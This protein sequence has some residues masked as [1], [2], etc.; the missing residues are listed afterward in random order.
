LENA[1]VTPKPRYGRPVL[2]NATGSPAGVAY[3]AAHSDLVFITSPAGHKIDAALGV[4]PA[5]N[6]A[7]KA[8][9]AKRG[10]KLRTIINPMIVCRETDREAQQYHQAILEAADHGAIEGFVTHQRAGDAVA[11]KAHGDQHRALGGN[12]QIIGSPEQVVDKLLG[13]KQ[14]GC[15]GVQ[16]AF[17]D[18]APDLEFFGEV[19]MPLIRQAGLRLEEAS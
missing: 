15:D 7:I 10:R 17:F 9:G 1:F 4:L 8:A 14:A 6:A 5:H 2:V 18:F 19:V 12:I 3:A 11:W 16:I 13:L